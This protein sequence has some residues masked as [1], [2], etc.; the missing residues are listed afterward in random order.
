MP[1]NSETYNRLLKALTD[2]FSGQ[3]KCKKKISN[4]VLRHPIRKIRKNAG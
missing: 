1:W 3:S 4:E 2:M